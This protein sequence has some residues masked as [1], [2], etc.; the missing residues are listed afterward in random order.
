MNKDIE[1]VLEKIDDELWLKNHIWNVN[2][3][4]NHSYH[5]SSKETKDVLLKYIDYNIQ[6][7]IELIRIERMFDLNLISEQE[8]LILLKEYKE[9]NK[10]CKMTLDQQ[11]ES[12]CLRQKNLYNK[13]KSL[14]ILDVFNYGEAITNEVDRRLIKR[15]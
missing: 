10:L 11:S 8:K 6:Q 2:D 1:V 13:F 4:I 5:I 12:L 7:I 14:G 15:K 3:L 9:Y